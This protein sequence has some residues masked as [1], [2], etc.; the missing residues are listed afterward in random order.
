MREKLIRKRTAAWLALLLA[1][2]CL[3]LFQPRPPLLEPEGGWITEPY[4]YPLVPGTP[5][6]EQVTTTERQFLSRPPG[7]K[8]LARMSTPAL[9]Q[10]VLDYPYL[11]AAYGSPPYFKQLLR[12]PGVALLL[13]RPDAAQVLRAL[14]QELA[15]NE[16]E[17][18]LLL[19]IDDL[20]EILRNRWILRHASTILSV[21]GVL[22]AAAIILALERERDQPPPPPPSPRTELWRHAM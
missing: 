5:E 16:D 6:W 1:L 8:I 11:I 20:L 12:S 22:L 19:V 14:K 9:A 17:R 3:P 2:L 13:D 21:G 18:F 4:V 10:T 15:G 7:N